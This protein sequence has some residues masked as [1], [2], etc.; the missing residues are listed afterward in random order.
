MWKL[1][2]VLACA[3]LST[4]PRP[5]GAFNFL[6][7]HP[8]HSGSHEVQLRHLS[9]QLALR[10]HGVTYLKFKNFVQLPPLEHENITSITLAVDN[11]DG[12]VPFVTPE[13]EG[14]FML[15]LDVM[16]RDGLSPW[17][18]PL[19]AFWT[20]PAH[21]DTLLRDVRLRRRLRQVGFHVALV[22]LLSNEC[23]LALAHALGVPAVAYWALP[24]TGG[25]ATFSAGMSSPSGA[26]PA[27][28]ST[29]SDAMN[30]LQRGVNLF[31][32]AMNQ[33]LMR[34]QFFLADR[35]IQRHLP[36][37]PDSQQL[38][39]NL[40]GLLENS[41]FSVDYPR[42]YPPNVVNVGC[43]QCREPHLL[44][45][46][47]EEFMRGS[48]EAGVVLFSMGATFD[49]SIAPPELLQKLL[50]AFSRL[51]Q[52]VVMKISGAL[53]KTLAVPSNVRIERWLPQQ[54]VLG[55]PKTRV[56]FTHCG[57]HGAME[58]VWHGVPAVAMPVYGDQL[59][60]SSLLVR[61]G[62]A[63]RLYKES[64]AQ[65]ILHAVTTVLDDPSFARRAAEAKRVMRDQLTSPLERAIWFVEHVA[66]TGGAPH[67]KLAS[68]TLSVVQKH[69]LDVMAAAAAL[70]AVLVS[71]GLRWRPTV[72][73]P[74]LL[75]SHRKTS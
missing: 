56:F 7:L 13:K 45:Q 73:P 62:L 36:G 30:V 46:E 11:S 16:W 48:G 69:N 37:S 21:C 70:L 40:S 8:L 25:E 58:T 34:F 19:D 50:L 71:V 60:V 31:Y 24:A 10:G 65:Q 4:A 54:D 61:R 72:G 17:G 52:R 57:L 29:Y 44:P 33:L 15:P 20:V 14:R 27:F 42:E 41:D 9:Q 38:L 6:V 49:A 43:M 39:A 22:D 1:V 51:R 18:V 2:A 66:R 68:R 53:P 12:H 3:V 26:V 64:S 28:M 35:S 47:L 23:G 74:R 59:D 5:I 75:H 32:A 63:V 67:L 55:H